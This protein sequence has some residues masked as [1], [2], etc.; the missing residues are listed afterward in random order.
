MNE[1]L[2]K[3]IVAIEQYSFPLD[4]F[5]FVKSEPVNDIHSYEQLESLIGGQ[6]KSGDLSVVKDGLSNVLYWGYATSKGRRS[7]RVEKFRSRV[8]N[9]QLE[10]FIR[11]RDSYAGLSLSEIK[12][13]GMPQFSNVS[14][15]SKILMFLS[16]EKYV[17]LDLQLAKIKKEAPS[18]LFEN[19]V[20]YE[21]SIPINHANC[22]CYQEWCLFCAYVSNHLLGGRCRPVDVERGIFTIVK[23]HSASEAAKTI[24]C[25]RA[26]A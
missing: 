23:K 13:I 6:L 22:S 1:R 11:M 10:R 9:K 20:A 26:L 12:S 17:V 15:V 25:I 3:L 2:A 21:T 8:T 7:D 19:L 16:P 14:F 24:E 18:S 5:D 4:C